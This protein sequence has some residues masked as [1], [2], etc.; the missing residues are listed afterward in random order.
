MIDIPDELGLVNPVDLSRLF[1]HSN[2][3]ETL[4]NL[5]SKV[6]DEQYAHIGGYRIRIVLNDRMPRN[7]AFFGGTLFRFGDQTEGV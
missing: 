4:I 5:F 7:C 3:L 2:D 1:V 6:S